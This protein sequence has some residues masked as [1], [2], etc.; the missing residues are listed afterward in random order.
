[1][2]IKQIKYKPKPKRCKVCDKEFMPYNSIQ[3]VCSVG[4]LMEYNSKKSINKRV[5]EMKNNLKDKKWYLEALQIVFNKYIVLRDAKEPCVSCG[6]SNALQWDCGHY[7]SR[8]N[9]SFLRFNEDNCHKQCNRPCNTDL[10]GNLTEYRKGL[11]EKIGLERVQWLDEHCHDKLEL[12]IAEIQV[13]IRK[14][15]DKIKQQLL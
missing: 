2:S 8:G 10:S 3:P 4:C 15:K 9:Y 1:M 11:I 7:Y 12:T 14:Y 5:K 13:L 6:R